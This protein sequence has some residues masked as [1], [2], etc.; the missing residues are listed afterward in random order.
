MPNRTSL[1][2]YVGAAAVAVGMTLAPI[3][4]A[5]AHA[6]SADDQFVAALHAAGVPYK[7]NTFAKSVARGVCPQVKSGVKSLTWLGAGL[8]A[9]GIPRGFAT[10]VAGMAVKAYCPEKIKD[11]LP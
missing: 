1:S 10:D 2:R 4:T 3:A 7:N 8:V 5:P 6:D 9:S 11:L